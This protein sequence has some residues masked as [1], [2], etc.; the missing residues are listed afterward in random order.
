MPIGVNSKNELVLYWLG[1]MVYL[2]IES[3]YMIFVNYTNSWL[4][5]DVAISDTEV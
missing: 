3:P 2:F 1:V 5:A 4:N